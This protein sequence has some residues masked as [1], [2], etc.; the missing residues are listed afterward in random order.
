M[1]YWSKVLQV[2]S[3]K[4][5]DSRFLKKDEVVEC[6]RTLTMEA[7]LVDIGDPEAN[8]KPLTNLNISGIDKKLNEVADI[9]GQNE[10]RKSMLQST[11]PNKVSNTINCNIR[12]NKKNTLDSR[13]PQKHSVAIPSSIKVSKKTEFGSS[14]ARQTHPNTTH[15]PLKEW[16]VLYTTQITQKAKRY[17]DGILRLAPCGSHNNQIFLLDEDGAVLNSK[18]LKSAENVKKGSKIEL[19]NYL[20]EV[21]DPR[22]LLEEGLHQ[23]RLEKV[24]CSSCSSDN[25]FTINMENLSDMVLPIEDLQKGHAEQVIGSIGSNIWKSANCRRLLNDESLRDASQI[26]SVLQKPL[27]KENGDQRKLP[28]DQAHSSPSSDHSLLD[29]QRLTKELSV[30]ETNFVRE[31]VGDKHD[32]DSAGGAAET[33][34]S[35]SPFVNFE[36]SQEVHTSSIIVAVDTDSEKKLPSDGCSS[37]CN[38]L[39]GQVAPKSSATIMVMESTDESNAGMTV[40][41][42]GSRVLDAH[43]CTSFRMSQG[44]A[45]NN[46]SADN[47]R[48]P[49]M[50]AAGVLDVYSMRYEAIDQICTENKKDG[51]FGGAYMLDGSEARNATSTNSECQR[52]TIM[53]PDVDEMPTFDLGF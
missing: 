8:H 29:V 6:G 26:L 31:T 35:G 53:F 20:V 41:T 27:P 2:T 10:N 22:T 33:S 13:L 1:G 23:G 16:N 47:D 19:S 37:P 49:G 42:A 32:H 12:D 18:F 15:M 11:R 17:H 5:I 44:I 36:A 24:A 9:Q 43:P 3:E 28:V 4:L 25:K 50:N 30:P 38:Q 52:S 39:S 14:G 46:S 21:C 34:I 45:S 48:S 40:S 7:H 51:T